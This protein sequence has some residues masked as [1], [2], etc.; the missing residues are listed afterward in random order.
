MCIRDRN[1]IAAPSFFQKNQ[2][3]IRTAC[4]NL[5]RRQLCSKNRQEYRKVLARLYRKQANQRRDFHFKLAKELCQKYAVICL[6]SLSMKAMQQGHGKKVN[7]Y[8]F[9]AFENILEYVGRQMGTKII[10]VD[11]FYP[12]SQ[13]C[14]DCGYQN[15]EVKNIRVSEWTCPSCGIHHLSLIHI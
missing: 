2:K 15:K 12:S 3:A 5:S 4:R 9:A 10:K 8:G 6:E 11:T 1:D 7:D 13:I 14:H